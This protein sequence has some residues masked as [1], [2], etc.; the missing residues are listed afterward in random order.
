MLSGIYRPI[1]RWVTSWVNN[2][3]PPQ[4][5]KTLSHKEIFV[6]P[7]RW[8]ILFSAM[9]VITLLTGINYQNSMIMAVALFLLA[10]IILN[11]VLT[12]RNLSGLEIAFRRAEPCFAGEIATF[13]FVLSG[14]LQA[15]RTAR[16]MGI[17]L[18]W[19]SEQYTF[20]NIVEPNNVSAFVPYKT[21]K[22]GLVFTR[23]NVADHDLP[24]WF[25]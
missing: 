10:V 8:G 20:L 1:N 12:Y 25:D 18:G 15:N 5:E 23:Q 17:E 6:L 21:S 16:H 4:K 7:T 3:I 14:R 13:E 24:F 9:I 19:D 2:R 22:R 11:I